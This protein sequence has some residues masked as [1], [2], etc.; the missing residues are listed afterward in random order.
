MSDTTLDAE[1]ERSI[2]LTAPTEIVKDCGLLNRA[3]REQW[4]IPAARRNVIIDRLMDIVEKTEV[5]VAT[6]IGPMKLEG[7]ADANAIAAARTLV[8]MVGQNQKEEPVTRHVEHT[9]ELGPITVA[10]MEERRR[11]LREM[12]I[13]NTAGTD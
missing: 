2:L 8:A 11:Q 6:K 1:S 3:I 13:A 5:T 10:N 7:P 4:P 12:V 9:H